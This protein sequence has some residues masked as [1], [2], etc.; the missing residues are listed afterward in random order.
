MHDTARNLHE[1]KLKRLTVY[2]C[3]STPPIE[4]SPGGQKSGIFTAGSA[5][6]SLTDAYNLAV[7]RGWESKSVELQQDDAR[8]T[9]EPKHYLTPEQREIASR[10]EGLKLSRSRILDQFHST[11]NPRYRTILEQALAALDEHIVR[12]G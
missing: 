7:A 8:F 5:Y 3:A 4:L 11:E 2:A 1:G 10:R 6:I 9:G 12:L